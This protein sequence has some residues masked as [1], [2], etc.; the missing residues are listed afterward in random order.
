MY[1]RT[2]H[3][4]EREIVDVGI[5]EDEHIQLFVPMEFDSSSDLKVFMDEY[6]IDILVERKRRL[7]EETEAISNAEPLTY[8]SKLPFLGEYLPIQIIDDGD[9]REVFVQNQAI[10]MKAEL[11]SDGIRASHLKLCRNKAYEYLKLKVDH[12]AKL[13]GVRYSWLE[14][15]DGR[16]TWGMFH[17]IDKR[18]ILSRRLMM[19]SE[20][21]IDSIV[22]HELAHG[23]AFN[24][25]ENHD[26]EMSKILPDYEERDEAFYETC[27][28]LIEQG[29]I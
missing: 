13:I 23:L 9:S 11:S 24:H 29:W 14:I 10:H 27:R 3:E 12:Y 2:Y 4:E 28:V 18:I 21:V 20:F 17:S 19:M 15:D 26:F 8:S 7:D 6:G 16:R 5:C 25:D 22:V 1:V